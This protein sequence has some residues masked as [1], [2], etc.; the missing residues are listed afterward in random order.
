MAK[1]GSVRSL[2]DTAAAPQTCQEPEG[3]SR[4]AVHFGIEAQ[5]EF[6]LTPVDVSNDDHVAGL[7]A[8]VKRRG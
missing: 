1:T 8:A 6:L 3:V 5:L 2:A 4:A 7:L